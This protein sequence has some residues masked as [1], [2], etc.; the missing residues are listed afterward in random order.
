MCVIVASLWTVMMLFYCL[1]YGTLYWTAFLGIVPIVIIFAIPSM[2]DKLYVSERGI[3]ITRYGKERHDFAWEDVTVTILRKM[4]GRKI[5]EYVEFR[6][7]EGA[8]KLEMYLSVALKSDLDEN[9]KGAI[10]Y[11][12]K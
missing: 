11:I 12:S 4:R 5:L 1:N 7:K 3:K 8:F 6:Q 9:Y 2:L 10:P